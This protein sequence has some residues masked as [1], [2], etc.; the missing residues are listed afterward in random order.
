MFKILKIIIFII[1]ITFIVVIFGPR[2]KKSGLN[3]NE[4]SQSL[5]NFIAHQNIS[6]V[7][8]GLKISDTSL[9]T[10]INVIHSLP[11]NEIT[12]I[13]NYLCQPSSSSAGI[14]HP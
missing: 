6:P 11:P 4:I 14:I 12:Q 3:L 2:I 10:L 13:K 7:V 5:D 9:D 8:L 1:V